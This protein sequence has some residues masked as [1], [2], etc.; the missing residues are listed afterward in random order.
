[1]IKSVIFDFGG[2]CMLPRDSKRNI[3]DLDR[4]IFTNISKKF[5][6]P[7]GIVMQAMEKLIVKYQRGDVSDDDFRLAFSD[8]VGSEELKRITKEEWNEII[9]GP[10]ASEIIRNDKVYKLI[11]KLKK[12]DIEVALLSNTISPHA[13]FFIEHGY[14]E[15]F[16]TKILSYEVGARKPE[17]G[18]YE[19]ALE[20]LRSKQ[21]LSELQPGECVYVDDLPRYVRAAE[22]LGI[23]AIQYQNPK[24]LVSDLRKLN[25]EI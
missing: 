5:G 16:D 4:M 22:E 6:L 23:R 15:S 1:M 19:A 20:R 7:L 2:V 12:A 13:E 9:V 24:Q 8:E 10:Y 14:F 25:V 21:R 18:I 17:E 3:P 11:E